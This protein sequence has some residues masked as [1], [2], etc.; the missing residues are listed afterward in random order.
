MVYH[1]LCTKYIT[2]NCKFNKQHGIYIHEKH[3]D[4]VPY[5]F[6]NTHKTD[7]N[8]K[9]EYT[10]RDSFGSVPHLECKKSCECRHLDS[11]EELEKYLKSDDFNFDMIS[12]FFIGYSDDSPDIRLQIKNI[13]DEYNIDDDIIKT[14]IIT[15]ES[16]PE[17]IPELFELYTVYEILE[18][19]HIKYMSDMP[20]EIQQ[21]IINEILNFSEKECNKISLISD[22]DDLLSIIKTEIVPLDQLIKQN[23]YFKRKIKEHVNFNTFLKFIDYCDLHYLLNIANVKLNLLPDEDIH[24]LYWS[25]DLTIDE[26]KSLGMNDNKIISSLKDIFELV[27]YYNSYSRVD[28]IKGINDEEVVELLELTIN[29][30]E[31]L[32]ENRQTDQYV[33]TINCGFETFVIWIRY[34]AGVSDYA[35]QKFFEEVLPNSS[36]LRSS[37]NLQKL[38]EYMWENVYSFPD[39]FC[40]HM[41]PIVE[42]CKNT[43]KYPPS[44]FKAKGIAYRYIKCHYTNSNI[45]HDDAY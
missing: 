27:R 12:K 39:T 44:K 9:R 7:R 36:L 2:G 25:K 38:I 30:Q 22:E 37:E 18:R 24:E 13:C 20:Y 41:S 21:N 29:D 42:F 28:K 5:C 14:K 6:E 32:K 23:N 35:C 34:F 1:I 15:F 40:Q 16:F 17:L 11:T 31:Y 4:L 45:K 43:L 33:N 3:K 10:Y 19:F 26:L 8:P